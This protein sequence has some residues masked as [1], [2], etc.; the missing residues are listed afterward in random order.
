MAIAP[1]VCVDICERSVK[2]ACVDGRKGWH[3]NTESA[4]SRL[5][6]WPGGATRKV[7]RPEKSDVI[8]EDTLGFGTAK[9][10]IASRAMTVHASTLLAPSQVPVAR[11]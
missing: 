11:A 10:V 5:S 4:Q 2:V 7:A 8:C 6:D 3:N 1:K 9:A